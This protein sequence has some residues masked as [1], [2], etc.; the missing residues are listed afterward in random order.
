MGT[1]EVIAGAEQTPFIL[2]Y[3]WTFETLQKCIQDYT[4]NRLG[5]KDMEVSQIYYKK[6]GKSRTVVA[7]HSDMDI[8]DFLAEYPMFTAC[9]KPSKKA[10]MVM[11]VDLVQDR[12]QTSTRVTPA[13][14]HIDVTGK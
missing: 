4:K 10:V 12:K 2:P 1:R 9:G 6:S 11:A 7:M 5:L 13:K 8:P 3:R 14:S